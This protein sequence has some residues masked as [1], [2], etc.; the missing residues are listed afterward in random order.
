MI[1]FLIRGE[2]ESS[3]SPKYILFYI[4]IHFF[5]QSR[6]SLRLTKTIDCQYVGIIL[7]FDAPQ[8]TPA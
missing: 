4:R 3:T 5:G 6:L 7:T 1:K 8:D 2:R